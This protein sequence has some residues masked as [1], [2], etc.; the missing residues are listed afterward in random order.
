MEY[1]PD[2]RVSKR[3]L[4]TENSYPKTFV[5]GNPKSTRLIIN[6]AVR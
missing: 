4:I 6:I 1:I 5:R 3:E 2:K